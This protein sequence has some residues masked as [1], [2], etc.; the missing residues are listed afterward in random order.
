MQS[1]RSRIWTRVAV[2]ISCEDNQYTTG[3][4]HNACVLDRKKKK[5]MYKMYVQKVQK[6]P[7]VPR[8]ELNLHMP[9]NRPKGTRKK[10]VL[11]QRWQLDR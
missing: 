3:T 4:S 11:F 9:E 8:G 7:E 5:K 6:F 2:S 10:L 1:V